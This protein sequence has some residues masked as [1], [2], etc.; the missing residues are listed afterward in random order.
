MH[1]HRQASQT[2]YNMR[3]PPSAKCCSR[4]NGDTLFT[5]QIHG[6]HL[7]SDA[8]LASDIVDR[9]DPA[10]VK[11]DSFCEGSLPTGTKSNELSWACRWIMCASCTHQFAHS[12]VN[13][14]RDT[15]VSVRLFRFTAQPSRE[16]P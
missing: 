2:T 16:L 15:N 13:V 7:G 1:F 8:I 3:I 12:P 14:C 10:R 6:V 11:Q 4:L 5:F 9:V